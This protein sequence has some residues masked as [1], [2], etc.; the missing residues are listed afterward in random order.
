MAAG[1]QTVAKRQKGDF[2]DAKG[3]KYVCHGET[4]PA[5]FHDKCELTDVTLRPDIV[6]S[7]IEQSQVLVRQCDR[8]LTP[9]NIVYGDIHGA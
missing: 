6:R 8:T 7:Q 1:N 2:A 9:I 5:A 4:K 3:P